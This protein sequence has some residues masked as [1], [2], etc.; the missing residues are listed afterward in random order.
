MIAMHSYAMASDI[1]KRKVHFI[2][3][4]PGLKHANYLIN[5]KALFWPILTLKLI[6]LFGVPFIA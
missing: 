4:L 2:A 1:K 6:T 5:N 3:G